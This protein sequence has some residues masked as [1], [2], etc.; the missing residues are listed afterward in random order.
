M[1][2]DRKLWAPPDQLWAPYDQ[3]WAPPDQLWAPPDQTWAPP[4][5]GRPRPD[6]GRPIL[7]P[8]RVYNK[9]VCDATTPAQLASL[10]SQQASV[11]A[12]AGAGGRS[13]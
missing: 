9:R 10:Y 11:A 7:D 5:L 2:T 6:L 8:T 12:H 13:M 3:L 4:D 1:R